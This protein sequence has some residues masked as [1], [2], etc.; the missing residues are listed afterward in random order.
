LEK[1]TRTT[2]TADVSLEVPATT[3]GE[4]LL[5]RPAAAVSG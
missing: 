3:T 5:G 1:V 2:T 4:A